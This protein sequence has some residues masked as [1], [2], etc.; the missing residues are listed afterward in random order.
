MALRLLVAVSASVGGLS[1]QQLPTSTSE[2]TK[3]LRLGSEDSSPAPLVELRAP[4]NE[5]PVLE[6]SEPVFVTQDALSLESRPVRKGRIESVAEV[7]DLQ[8]INAQMQPARIP[9]P[10]GQQGLARIS[11]AYRQT[12]NPE[13]SAE[14]P[15][16]AL[17]VEQHI[18]LDTSMVLE[19]VD[20][21][22]GANPACA[23]EITKAAIKASEADVQMVVDIVETA[24]SAAPEQ[25]RIISQ[26]AMATMPEATTAIQVLLNRLDPG[27]SPIRSS[28]DSKDS[29][30]A[31][32]L[33]EEIEKAE[34]WDPLNPPS[35][36]PTPFNDIVRFP[37]LPPVL[38][39]PA[40]ISPPSA[41]NV[42]PVGVPI[43]PPFILGGWN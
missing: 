13:G 26:C 38:L 25:M 34:P 8:T 32:S 39:P 7:V 21:E 2:L 40:I 41:T 43:K 6:E 35:G 30:D 18:L 29:K 20:T 22:V 3:V 5:E 31:E 28:K 1:A 27:Q 24:I 4:Q 9:S 17:S 14:C 37:P 33:S 10:K 15:T 16:V 42:N 23:C 19:I 36:P 12:G 11:A